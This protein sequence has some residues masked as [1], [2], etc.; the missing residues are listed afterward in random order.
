MRPKLPLSP[1]VPLIPDAYFEIVQAGAVHPMFL[2]MDLGT[3]SS[4]VWRR[5]VELYLKLAVS[6][7]FDRLFHEKRFRT[8][9]VLPS[10]RRLESI[11]KTI[12]GRTDKLFWFSTSD[13][14]QVNGL[15]G[16]VWLRAVGDGRLRIL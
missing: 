14:I 4:S 11:R 15:W 16:Q 13:E 10:I 2:E 5:K 7:E 6:G 1:S 12:A 9:I 8:L 3:E